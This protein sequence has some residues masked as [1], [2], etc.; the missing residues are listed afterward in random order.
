MLLES[1]RLHRSQFLE[2]LVQTLLL[3]LFTQLLLLIIRCRLS[4]VVVDVVHDR[5]PRPEL[6]SRTPAYFAV[7][8]VKFL[9]VCTGGG[10][11][12]LT[13]NSLPSFDGTLPPDLV[14]VYAAIGAVGLLVVGFSLVFSDLYRLALFQESSPREMLRA[15]WRTAGRHALL[16]LAQR[17]IWGAFVLGTGCLTLLLAARP[18]VEGPIGALGTFV[19]SQTLVLSNLV[20][21]VW[22]LSQAAR[23]LSHY[24]AEEWAEAAPR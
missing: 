1:L 14:F 17:A 10:G 19:L 13:L 24:S 8:V 7:T 16:L 4:A 11:L 12:L 23:K 2:G 21:E 5:P 9:L 22:W 6:F 20:V 15:A 18:L 3:L